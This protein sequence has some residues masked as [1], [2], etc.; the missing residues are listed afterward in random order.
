[1]NTRTSVT[2]PFIPETWLIDGYGPAGPLVTPGAP[3]GMAMSLGFEKTV[4]PSEEDG[5]EVATSAVP[6][7]ATMPT[8]AA[9]RRDRFRGRGLATVAPDG[10]GPPRGGRG[11]S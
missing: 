4:G 6:S 7:T 3:A 8:A 9:I 2:T 10:S 1:M 5:G 11:G